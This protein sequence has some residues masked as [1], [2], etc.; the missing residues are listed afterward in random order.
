MFILKPKKTIHQKEE[1]NMHQFAV[2]NYKVR[3]LSN[4]MENA[5]LIL[6][7]IISYI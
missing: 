6:I 5:Y 2:Y 7:V 4:L 1:K 3:T